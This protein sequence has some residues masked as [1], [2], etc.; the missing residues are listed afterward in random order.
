MNEHGGDIEC[1]DCVV[2]SLAR[3]V[4]LVGSVE[5]IHS[6]C[7]AVVSVGLAESQFLVVLLQLGHEGFKDTIDLRVLVLNLNSL[8]DT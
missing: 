2:I 5:H 1:S 3:S 4:L 6:K 8:Q 7:F